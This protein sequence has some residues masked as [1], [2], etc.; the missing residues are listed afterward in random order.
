MSLL[1]SITLRS[2]GI[3]V[4]ICGVFRTRSFVFSGLMSTLFLQHHA[5]MF[6]RSSVS[7]SKAKLAHAWRTGNESYNC[8]PST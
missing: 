6:R 2:S 5:A 3:F 4:S 1:S 8:E 7:R